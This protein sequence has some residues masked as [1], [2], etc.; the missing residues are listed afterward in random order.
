MHRTLM[1]VL[2]I[3]DLY[4]NNPMQAF[5]RNQSLFEPRTGGMVSGESE[6]PPLEAGL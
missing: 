3:L 1:K 6:I 2:S 4:H 5:G